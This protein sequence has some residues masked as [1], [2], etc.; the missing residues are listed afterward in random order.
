MPQEAARV[1]PTRSERFSPTLRDM[2]SFLVG[3]AVSAVFGAHF[4][5]E[6]S[7]QHGFRQIRFLMGHTPRAR[8]AHLDPEPEPEPDRSGLTPGLMEACFGLQPGSRDWSIRCRPWIST[9]TSDHH[10]NGVQEPPGSE[11]EQY[12][13]GQNPLSGCVE[14]RANEDLRSVSDC[15]KWHESISGQP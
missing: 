13:D 8:G 10:S 9:G 11:T 12:R 14:F 5:P 7:C 15:G 6:T 2:V 3:P 1:E 4:A